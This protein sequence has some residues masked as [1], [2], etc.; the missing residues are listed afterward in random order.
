MSV[1]ASLLSVLRW[2]AA[3]SLLAGTASAA[4]LDVGQA[5]PDFKLEGVDEAI[6]LS[7][8]RGH[9]VYVDF[10][11]SWCVPC[12]QSFPWMNTLQGKFR[13]KGLRVVAINL[14]ETVDASK[15]FLTRWPPNFKIAFDPTG[16]TPRA[17]GLLG[18]P[19]SFLIGRD[20]K[21]IFRHLGF[22][23]SDRAELEARIATALAAS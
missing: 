3:I 11:A 5:A 2:I 7:G 6:T 14:D 12:R 22:R 9:L 16:I 17:F 4:A 21:V 19:T 23:N 20:G 18:M 1:Y 10:W 15:E 13:D 8:L